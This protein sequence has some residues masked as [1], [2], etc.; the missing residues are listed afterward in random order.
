MGQMHE[1]KAA[2]GH[3]FVA[4]AA[5]PPGPA[6][7][8][9]VIIQE[10]FGLTGQ[11]QRCADRYALAGYATVVPALFDR[12][13]RGVQIGYGEFQRGGTLAMSIPEDQ[14]QADVMAC[15]DFV[16]GA[17]RAGIMGFCWGGT[18]AFLAASELPF[19]CAVSW[20][21]G[22]IGRLLDRCRPKVPVQYHFGEKDTFIPPATIE[23]IR[24]TDPGGEFYIYEGAGHGFHCDDREGYAPEA[25]RLGDERALAFL[26]RHL[27][28]P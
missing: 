3:R 20:Y 21:G 19:A 1:L 4:Y 2:D 27:G 15:R 26:A 16:A 10:I 13:E 24:A 12:K 23:R 18:I 22:G 9:L 7:G 11:M 8:G 6:R 25:A 17:G 14:V 28:E 5:E